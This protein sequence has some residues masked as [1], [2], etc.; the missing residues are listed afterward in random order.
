[1]K[2][3]SRP[4]LVEEGEQRWT[5]RRGKPFWINRVYTLANKGFDYFLGEKREHGPVGPLLPRLPSYKIPLHGCTP[6]Q[7]REHRITM[8]GFTRGR[9]FR[10]A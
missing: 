7:A 1:M 6:E 10:Q 2:A 8:A 3:Q 4:F 5:N 9:G